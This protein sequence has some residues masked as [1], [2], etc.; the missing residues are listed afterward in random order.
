MT[1][2]YITVAIVVVL[3]GILLRV[4]ASKGGSTE[5]TGPSFPLHGPEAL[6]AAKHY[7]YFPQI[8]Q[9]LSAADTEYL[10]RAAPAHVAKRALRERRA[11]ARRFLRGLSEDFSNLARLGR[12]IAALSPEVSR[13]QET[14]R[15][16]LILKFQILYA[17]VWLRLSGGAL[18]IHQLEVLTGLIGR[19]ATRMDEAMSE[20]SALSARELSGR[21]GA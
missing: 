1:E 20:V 12:V 7:A 3:C 4:L 6:R 9:A 17:L 16:F 15:L 19:L 10:L 2:T 8:R 14:A 11:I 18:P 13:E 21:L 5:G